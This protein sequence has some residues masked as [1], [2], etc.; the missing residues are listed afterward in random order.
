MFTVLG[1]SLI[2][3]L[4]VATL[5]PAAPLDRASQSATIATDLAKAL[6]EQRL[7]AIA[8]QDPDEPDRCIAALFFANSQLLV[9]SARYA[10]PSL[11]TAR[12][13]QKQ[14][15][16]VYLDLSASSIADTSIVIH[17]LNAD[18]LCARRDQAADVV[19]DRSQIAKIF[20]GDWDK[21]KSDKT[22]EQQ[23]VAAD[24]QYSRLL[25]ILLAQLRGAS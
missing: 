7:D 9:V 17:D 20:D 25:K 5:V 16:D 11:L 22:Y 1:R 21:H 12:L 13:A 6:S 19:Y 15:R 4:L 3:V 18:G 24:Q 2:L 10:S 14:Y 8:A 23:F